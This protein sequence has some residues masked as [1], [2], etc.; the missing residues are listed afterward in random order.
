MWVGKC[1]GG[2]LWW[3]WWSENV[4]RV[5]VWQRIWGYCEERGCMA[6]W[7][8]GFGPGMNTIVEIWMRLLNWS[9]EGSTI[10]NILDNSTTW[11]QGLGL[12]GQELII[13]T[14]IFEVELWLI[15]PWPRG[16][17]FARWASCFSGS[18]NPRGHQ[19]IRQ[20]INLFIK[21]CK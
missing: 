12:F 14:W 9:K 10:L 20:S 1:G 7:L 8:I 13:N 4:R 2:G 15:V 5:V 3:I 21:W 19:P 16:N 11:G 6:I 18:P 17:L